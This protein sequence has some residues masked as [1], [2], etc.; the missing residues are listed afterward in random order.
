ML[1][2]KF[3]LAFAPSSSR[4]SLHTHV[5]ASEARMGT[6]ADAHALVV[7]ARSGCLIV[8]VTQALLLAVHL[9]ARIKLLSLDTVATMTLLVGCGTS[10]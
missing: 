2:G 1:S 5:D 8:E 9:D 6:T 7:C 3:N 10:E 4:A